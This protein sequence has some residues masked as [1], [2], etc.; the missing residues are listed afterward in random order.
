MAKRKSGPTPAEDDGTLKKVSRESLD[1]CKIASNLYFDLLH[2]SFEEQ[3]KF[4]RMLF[5]W[6]AAKGDDVG[7]AARMTG[8]DF[9]VVRG[10]DFFEYYD[11]RVQ[12]IDQKRKP[13]AKTLRLPS[14]IAE[15]RKQ[16]MSLDQA[17]EKISK[18]RD[19]K[20]NDPSSVKRALARQKS[21]QNKK[22]RK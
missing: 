17:C 19:W 3:A 7:D 13:E 2:L 12:V 9:F 22:P 18:T 15:L 10:N 21:R 5:E 16:G 6:L 8:G 1:Q 4:L 20:G 14:Q 11:S